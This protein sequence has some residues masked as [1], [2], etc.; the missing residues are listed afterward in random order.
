MYEPAIAPHAAPSCVSCTKPT[1]IEQLAHVYV[2]VLR[3]GLN[4]S[5]DAAP[6]VSIVRQPA[7]ASMTANR[8]TL[9]RDLVEVLVS[10]AVLPDRGA[11]APSWSPCNTH[12]PPDR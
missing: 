4:V 3:V 12:N 2:V 5:A 1:W 8:R 7:A 10:I 6:A 9:V 11:G